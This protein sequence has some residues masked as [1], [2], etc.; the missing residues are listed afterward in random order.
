MEKD[1]WMSNYKKLQANKYLEREADLHHQYKRE[2]DKEI[3]IA[4][5]RLET[6]ATKVKPSK[7]YQTSAGYESGV[8]QL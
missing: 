8:M 7:L 5:D 6:E 1:V 3:E 2:R 4:I